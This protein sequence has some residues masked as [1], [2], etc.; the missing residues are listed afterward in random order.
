[1]SQQWEFS[2]QK[3]YLLYGG[4][5][6][7]PKTQQK[8]TKPSFPYTPFFSELLEYDLSHVGLKSCSNFAK[9]EDNLLLVNKDVSISAF[10]G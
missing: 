3:C 10:L 2:E 1:M 8:K 4:K 5:K 9:S 6:P 7:T